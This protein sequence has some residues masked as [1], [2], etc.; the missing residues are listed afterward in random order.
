M[1]SRLF[2][3]S[4]FT[5]LAV[6]FLTSPGM[7]HPPQDIQLSYDSATGT[8]TATVTHVVDNPLEHYIRQ[9]VIE[10]G[11]KE[12]NMTE[13]SSQPDKSQFSYLYA[14]AALPSE[15]ITL[16]AVCNRYGS[17]VKKITIGQVAVSST[18]TQTL[19]STD[20]SSPSSSSASPG[21]EVI[22]I[23]TALIGSGVYIWKCQR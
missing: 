20:T 16:T 23:I 4:I 14:V 19:P 18:P 1:L 6:T 17:L 21:F 5:L 8:L 22:T 11:G 3:W 7:A 2:I 12:I 13:Y 15:E 9:T 10:K